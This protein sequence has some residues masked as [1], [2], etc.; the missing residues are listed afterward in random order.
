MITNI[1]LHHQNKGFHFFIFFSSTM[2]VQITPYIFSFKCSQNTD[3]ICAVI[4]IIKHRANKNSM[5]N[6]ETL[7]SIDEAVLDII[8]QR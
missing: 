6:S 2:K 1:C 3:V 5:G 8:A 7:Y 4:D